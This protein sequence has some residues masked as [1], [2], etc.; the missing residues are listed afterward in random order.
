[1]IAGQRR[2]LKRGDSLDTDDA[3]GHGV[4]RVE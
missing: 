1:M 3:D 2:N 4:S